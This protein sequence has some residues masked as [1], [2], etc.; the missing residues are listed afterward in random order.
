MAGDRDAV[1]P[2]DLVARLGQ[3]RLGPRHQMQRAALG[4]QAL[5]NR[6]ANALPG[7]GD[8]RRLAGQ[9]EIHAASPSVPFG[10]PDVADLPGLAAAL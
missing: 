9:S 6:P 4:R 3:R 10:G 1:A 8:Q 7:A 5:G 2:G